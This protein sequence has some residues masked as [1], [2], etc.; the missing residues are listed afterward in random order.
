M[1]DERPEG[2]VLR[3]DA[4]MAKR[5][6]RR[7]LLSVAGTAP[8]ILWV[9]D[10]QGRVIFINQRWTE[11]T[12]QPPEDA[13]GGGWLERVH[14]DDRHEVARA[15]EAAILQQGAY[16]AEY[17]L[18]TRE[19]A[20]I[21]VLDR[22]EPE[23]EG[24]KVVG[25]VGTVTDIT[26][27]K[28]AEARHRSALDQ[29]SAVLDSTSDAILVVDGA[30]V[31]TYFNRQAEEHLAPSVLTR[32]ASLPSLLPAGEQVGFFAWLRRVARQDRARTFQIYMP[33]TGR[34]LEV[35]AF[36]NGGQISL[37]A[38]DISERRALDEERRAAEARMAH[39]AR[40]DPL[41]G[42]PNRV[43]F[44]E[45]VERAQ[46][47]S[48]AFHYMDLDGFKEVNDTL[49]HLAGDELLRT[50]AER[51]RAVAPAKAVICLSAGM[52]SALSMTR[53]AS[54]SPACP[55]RSSR[56]SDRRSRSMGPW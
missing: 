25:Y 10:E 13:C 53:L 48:L 1:S 47:R 52:S 18:L 50:V 23:R 26:T 11:I 12:G 45:H 29:L 22:G 8:A 7:R 33:G 34:W 21:W 42:L 31:I 51:L 46:H 17:R 5:L 55:G 54:T 36:P 3:Y 16:G 19:G 15:F 37:F 14:P 32:G 56:P 27:R 39:A 30:G 2:S 40:H 24:G 20:P 38:R 4:A 41:T 6:S 49:G 9:S 35:R 43:V 44:A 28:A